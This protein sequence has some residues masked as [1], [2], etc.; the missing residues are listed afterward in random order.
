MK[1]NHRYA[2]LS[3]EAEF[4]YRAVGG[5]ASLKLKSA[6]RDRD[7]ERERERERERKTLPRLDTEESVHN[8]SFRINFPSFS[9]AY[10][11]RSAVS[12]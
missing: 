2:K 12:P 7:G 3:A 8:K 10:K 6:A 11:I 5:D 4:R 9:R 1:K